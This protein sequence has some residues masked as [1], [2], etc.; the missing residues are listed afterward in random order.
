MPTKRGR[1]PART[2]P[3]VA[4][5]VDKLKRANY[6]LD[7]VPLVDMGRLGRTG[8]YVRRPVQRGLTAGLGRPCASFAQKAGTVTS[9]VVGLLGLRHLSVQDLVMV[10]PKEVSAVIGG[11]REGDR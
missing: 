6:V 11:L 4:T 8:I 5:A 10:L 1:R 2:V 9:Q 3:L 7:S